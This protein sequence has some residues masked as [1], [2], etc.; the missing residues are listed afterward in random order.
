MSKQAFGVP[1][2]VKWLVNKYSLSADEAR[3]LSEHPFRSKIEGAVDEWRQ[4]H[5]WP[6]TRSPLTRGKLFQLMKG[7]PK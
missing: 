2:D 3:V 4:L 7:E 6:D 1:F 5:G